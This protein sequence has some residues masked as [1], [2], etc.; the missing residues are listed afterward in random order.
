[1][2]VELAPRSYEGRAMMRSRRCGGRLNLSVTCAVVGASAAFGVLNGSDAAIARMPRPKLTAWVYPETCVAPPHKSLGVEISASYPA[3]SSSKKVKHEYQPGH[4]GSL[5]VN[6][7]T[8][9][10]TFQGGWGWTQGRWSWWFNPVRV[11]HK[12][13]VRAVGKLAIVR[14][15]SANGRHVLYVRVKSQPCVY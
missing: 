8:Y 13:M 10:L 15:T 4:S 5:K 11:G 3:G 1:M 6:H 9:Q 2:L 7:H 14:Y 12:A